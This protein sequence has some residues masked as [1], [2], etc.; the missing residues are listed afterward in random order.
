MSLTRRA[1]LAGC[2]GGLAMLTGL[3][4]LAQPALAQPAYP[5]RTIKIVPYPA[6]GT[7]DFLGRLVADQLKTGPTP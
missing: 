5:S 7:T 1:A 3:P 6:G 4:A 2:G